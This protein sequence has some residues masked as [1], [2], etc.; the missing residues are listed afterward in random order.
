MSLRHLGRSWRTVRHYRPQQ[1]LYRTLIRSKRSAWR[2][3]GGPRIPDG[4]P[5]DLSASLPLPVLEP[6]AQADDRIRLLGRTVRLNPPLDWTRLGDEETTQLELFHLHY[7]DYLPALHDQHARNLILDWIKANPPAATSSWRA[8]W[9]PYVVAVRTVAWMQLLALRPDLVSSEEHAEVV[10][11]LAVQLRYLERNLE[12]DLGG[13][14]LVKDARALAWASAFFTGPEAIHWR[15]LSLRLLDEILREQIL[16]DGMHFERAPAYHLQV[17]ADLLDCRSLLADTP[18]ADRLDETLERM[19]Q[20]AVDLTHPD[21]LPSLM[22]DGGLH[23]AP[24][25]GPLVEALTKVTGVSA[26]SP[27]PWFAYPDAGYYGYRTDRLYLLVDCGPIG[28]DHLPAH[29]HGDILSFELSVDGLR[30]IVDAGTYEY[31]AGPHRE[32]SRSTE[33]HNTVT[34]DDLDQAELWSSFRV[35]R[36][37]RRIQAG[38]KTI[39][40]GFVFEGTHDAYFHLGGRPQHRRRICVKGSIIRV[41]DSIEGGIGQSARARLMIHPDVEAVD[42]EAGW[43]LTRADSCV[44]LLTDA[45]IELKEALWAPDLG[46]SRQTQQFVLEYGTAP[47]A[48]ALALE[49]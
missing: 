12:R 40:G 23:M 29:G 2:L 30:F 19:A 47:T 6:P 1:I 16:A 9:S 44:R 7:H 22:G 14:H 43:H 33:A 31:E 46:Q 18:M 24:P 15:E 21:G 39:D 5:P 4:P 38:V 17:L 11:S 28:P 41:D 49:T 8:A 35:G 3:T 27:S 26:P 42:T 48:S 25:A 36:R 34:L 20:V 13:N 45:K 32:W 10:R 37:P